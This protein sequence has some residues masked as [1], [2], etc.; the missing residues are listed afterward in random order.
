MNCGPERTVLLNFGHPLHASVVASLSPATEVR[1]PFNLEMDG[2]LGTGDQVVEIVNEAARRVAEKGGRLD[3]T[4]PVVV[5][6]PGVTEG[7]ALVL[8]ELHGRLGYFPRVL[9]LRKVDNGTF[10]L[11]GLLDLERLR[12]E[13]RGRR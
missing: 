13:A 2:V 11:R 3:G 1:V 8:T 9:Q 4:V 6:L 10:R 7:A 5:G 12:L